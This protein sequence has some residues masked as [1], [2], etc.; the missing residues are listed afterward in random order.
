MCVPFAQIV[1]GLFTN[2]PLVQ[3]DLLMMMSGPVKSEA[4]APV[5][6]LR[7]CNLDDVK[8]WTFPI[9]Q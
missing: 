7:N 4:A 8:V 2:M 3:G 5:G 1:H 9:S 6:Q